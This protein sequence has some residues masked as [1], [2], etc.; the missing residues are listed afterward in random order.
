MAV[1][2]EYL[3][4]AKLFKGGKCPLPPNPA[5][6]CIGCVGLLVATKAMNALSAEPSAHASQNEHAL[7][8]GEENGRLA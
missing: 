4:G 6:I 1:Y 3:R 5:S 8:S 7:I 2:E